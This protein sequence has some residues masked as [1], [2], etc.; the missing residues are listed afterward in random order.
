MRWSTEFGI[1]NAGPALGP[2][3]TDSLMWS[4]QTRI[5]FVF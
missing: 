3:M 2:M 5:A 4:L 1:M